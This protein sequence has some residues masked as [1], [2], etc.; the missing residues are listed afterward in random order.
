MSFGGALA[1]QDVAALEV[2]AVS[3]DPQLPQG[4]FQISYVNAQDERVY[5][6][7]IAYSASDTQLVA[8]VQAAMDTL[9]GAGNVTV[10]LDAASQARRAALTLS[11]GG[12]LAK[13]DAADIRTHFGSATNA[14]RDLSLA[15]V[16]PSNVAQG[17]TRTG[18]VQRIVIDSAQA[19]VAYTLSLAHS[20]QTYE[21]AVLST[22][23]TQDEVQAALDALMA[24]VG[25][26]AQAEPSIYTGRELRV[27]VQPQQI[28]DDQ[29]FALARNIAAKIEGE[30]QYPG[31][32]RVTVIR[33]TRCVE[34]AK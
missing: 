9:F 5:S 23:M 18:E 1:G 20:G 29:A 24:Q 15:V 3:V 30:L 22:E 17:E 25:A 32:I 13:V 33:E 7:A 21:S 19:E 28:N 2:A 4:K 34:V 31:Q 16:R 10:A 26:G 12:D 14:D 8:N 6:P 27:F 11:F